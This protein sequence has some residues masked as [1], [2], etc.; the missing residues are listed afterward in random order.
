MGRADLFIRLVFGG[1]EVIGFADNIGL[2]RCG[3]LYV[4][5]DRGES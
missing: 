1:W 3:F 4:S 5:G 2:I